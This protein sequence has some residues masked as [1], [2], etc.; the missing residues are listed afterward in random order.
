[1]RIENWS[2]LEDHLDWYLRHYKGRFFEILR[3][4]SSSR[5]FEIFDISAAESLSV[6]VPPRAVNW[7]L[8]EDEARDALLDE[9]DDALVP[10]KDALWTCDRGLL[11]GDRNKLEESGALFQ[12]YYQ[13][14]SHGIGPV[15]ASKLLAAK[16]PNVV[17][18]RDS[19]VEKLLEPNKATNW[20]LDIRTLFD[21]GDQVLADHL[22]RLPIPSGG[23]PVTTLRRLDII[24]WMEAKARGIRARS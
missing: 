5:R 8:R 7:L 24:L 15:T 14:K 4:K 2:R 22:D 3:E 10:G 11:I 17:P 18:I 1:M 13:L 23:P 19:L 9:V 21:D 20:W 12:L 16:Y 6:L